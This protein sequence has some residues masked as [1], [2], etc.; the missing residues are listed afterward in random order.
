M[1]FDILYPVQTP[2]FVLTTVANGRKMALE[3]E[4]ETALLWQLHI[5]HLSGEVRLEGGGGWDCWQ[6]KAK[7]ASHAT[8]IRILSNLGPEG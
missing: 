8:A 3:G 4:I 6:I 5:S 2:K 1:Q 7:L